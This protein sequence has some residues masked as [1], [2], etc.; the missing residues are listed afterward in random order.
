M[1]VRLYAAAVR[2]RME[3]R[4]TLDMNI[5]SAYWFEQYGGK[6]SLHLLEPVLSLAESCALLPVLQRRYPNDTKGSIPQWSA[7]CAE[8]GVRWTLPEPGLRLVTYF[9]H[10]NQAHSIPIDMQELLK[11]ERLLA[12]R[13]LSK[14]ELLTFLEHHGM[15]A[16]GAAWTSYVQAAYLRGHVELQGGLVAEWKRRYLW[17]RKVRGFRCR[18]CGTREDKM[19]RT[20]CLYCSGDCL[21]CEECLTMGRMQSC[22]LLITGHGSDQGTGQGVRP[23]STAALTNPEAYIG[24]WG[25]S[26]AQTEAAHQGLSYLA[27]ART[28]KPGRFLIWAVTGAGKTEMIFPFIDYELD[29]GHR[30]LIATP[31]RDVVLELQPRLQKAFPER[32]VVT[33]YGGS[34]ERWDRGEITLSTTH[35][36][37]RFSRSFDLVIVDEIDAFPYHNNPM[38]QYAAERVCKQSGAY[39]LLSATP[40]A[41]LMRQAKRKALHHVKVPVRYHRYPLPVPRTIAIK[42]PAKWRG[43]LPAKLLTPLQRSIERG[44]QLFVFVSRIRD[45]NPIVNVL[46]THFQPYAI[47]GTSSQDPER[48]QKVIQFRQAAIRI[49]VTTTILERGV[50]VPR[51]DVFI[52]QAD[53]PLFN[54]S[55]LVQMAG[56]AGRS[57]DDP[58]GRVYFAAVEYTNS[59]AEAIRQIR[60]MNR[61][62]SRKGYLINSNQQHIRGNRTQ[63]DNPKK[64]TTNGGKG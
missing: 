16:A 54:A 47:E 62:A 51:T 46:R 17:S 30:V 32:S 13:C 43:S 58:H 56:R 19:Y 55:A 28:E 35:Q 23:T 8:A 24:K 59:Q 37:L 60:A 38:L 22:S 3:W 53:S 42:D 64:D 29:R 44:A 7:V 57:K 40:P 26:P 15:E 10:S 63:E 9:E 48:A 39:V 21:Y 12:D 4:F 50:T 2:G 5:D 14:E 20:D 1:K 34:A 41:E 25:L 31:R 52:L 33:L 18:R 11:L 6:A 27:G 49:L 45:V 61:L 36:L